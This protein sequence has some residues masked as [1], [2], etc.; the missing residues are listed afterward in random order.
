MT[1]TQQEDKRYMTNRH[2]R[3]AAQKHV[4]NTKRDRVMSEEEAKELNARNKPKKELINGYID[5][6][7][8]V[9]KSMK[10]Y[11]DDRIAQMHRKFDLPDTVNM[12]RL[13]MKTK[14]KVL[15]IQGRQ[16]ELL[17]DKKGCY[18]ML[19]KGKLA[20]VMTSGVCMFVRITKAV[21]GSWAIIPA[22]VSMANVTTVQEVRK[23]SFSWLRRY[24][25]EISFDGYVQPAHLFFDY[26]LRPDMKSMTF[27]VTREYVKVKGENEDYNDYFRL[28]LDPK[29]EEPKTAN[30]EQATNQ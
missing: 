23:R 8:K 30:P 7:K 2:N 24:S 12:E 19:C 22:Q 26:G 20:K 11:I 14:V 25:Y 5:P 29:C 18:K 21:D 27:Y 4:R 10:D 1:Q 3:R 6:L 28:W 15:N 17:P 13:P 16:R 9:S